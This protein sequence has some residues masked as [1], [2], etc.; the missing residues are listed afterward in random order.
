MVGVNDEGRER[1]I[2]RLPDAWV[3]YEIENPRGLLAPMAVVSPGGLLAIPGNR[4]EAALMMHWEVIDLHQP[5]AEPFV[6]PGVLTFIEELRETPYYTFNARGGAFWGPGERLAIL[7]YYCS[8]SCTPNVHLTVFD[9][10]T[11]A[12]SQV[13]DAN[14]VRPY[15]AADG[16]GVFVGGE[17]GD[18]AAGILRP[19][20]RVID[21][22]GVGGEPWCRTRDRYR[23][24]YRD[25]GRRA[26]RAA[27][28]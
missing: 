27:E 16:S 19:D 20:G 21:A 15:W 26:C 24:G 13:D 8:S 14:D 28:G 22:T 5:Q 12:T 3:S 7:W 1:E 23:G 6:V 10:R 11:G 25:H 2:A 4:G 17:P 9:G 18:D